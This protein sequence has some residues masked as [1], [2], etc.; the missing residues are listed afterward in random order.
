M[1]DPD[2]RRVLHGNHR[3]GQ[4]RHARRR[5]P[6]RRSTKSRT[7][8]ADLLQQQQ[9]TLVE[10]TL[11]PQTGRPD[12]V[13]RS[14]LVAERSSSQHE[15]AR[16]LERAAPRRRAATHAKPR[17]DPPTMQRRHPRWTDPVSRCVLQSVD[18]QPRSGAA[19]PRRQAAAAIEES[20]PTQCTRHLGSMA[21]GHAGGGGVHAEDVSHEPADGLAV[22]LHRHAEDAV[23]I[24]RPEPRSTPS[25]WPAHRGYPRWTRWTDSPPGMNS[26]SRSRAVTMSTRRSW[27]SATAA[28]AR[29]REATP[30]NGGT[31]A[32]PSRLDAVISLAKHRGFVF[33][34]GEIY[35]GSRSA[36]DYG[37]LGAELKENIK[38]QWWQS[39]VRGRDDVVGLDSSSSCP[40]RSGKPPA[41]STSSP[42][43]WSSACPA[44]S[45]S[46][47]DHLEEEYEEK[48]GRP[49]ENGLKDIACANCG[50]RGRMDR[51][52][53]ILRPAQDLPRPGGQRR[54]C[55]TCAP[56][57]PRASS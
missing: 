12:P 15:N 19:P 11:R 26:T 44:T 39:V 13:S 33:Q 3:P 10:A 31:M 42:T 53:G 8:Q 49:A 57:R 17:A 51:T 46:A 9:A 41:T 48:K 20:E 47:P 32:A 22:C 1:A 35:G 27:M 50:T 43:R 28:T 36:W 37:P 7:Q 5:H 4:N 24:A 6:W 18:E 34:A 29:R 21:R 2:D 14:G 52:P 54:A 56:R 38:R 40:A 55:T 45:A 23:Q 16:W 30:G 25:G